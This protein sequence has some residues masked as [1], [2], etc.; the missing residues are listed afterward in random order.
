MSNFPPPTLDA[1]SAIYTCPYC[2][3]ES[4]GSGT[5][6]LHCGAPVDVRARVSA[7]GWEA[8]PA[9]KDM[10][11]IQ[12]GHSTCQI[13]GMYVPA[14]ELRLAQGE[15]V[16]FSHHTLLWADPKVQLGN[17]PMKGAWNRKMAGMDLVM[18]EATGPGTLA[19][20]D[21]HAG[22]TIAVPL[23][24]G[25]TVDV[26]E[27]RFLTASLNVSYD[28]YSPG[29]WYTTRSGDE[30]ETHYPVGMYVDRF[31]ATDTPGLLMLHGRGNVFVR[32]LQPGQ[33]ICV[34]PGSFVWKDSSVALIMHLERPASGG[35]FSSW[36]PSTPW[37]RFTGPGRVAVSSA[38]ERMENTGRIVN[39]SSCT[40]MDWNNRRASMQVDSMRTAMAGS[41]DDAPF[42]AALDAFA[43]AQGFAAGKDKNRGISKA[44]QYSHPAGI[45]VTCTVVDTSVATAA[46]GNIAGVLGSR[47]SLLSG[48]L[49]SMV[50]SL[51]ARGTSGGDQV[52]GLGFPA[53]WK[54]K[55]DTTS[56]L[57]ITKNGRTF[58]VE[59]QGQMPAQDQLG[60]L[61]AFAAAGLP[62][63]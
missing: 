1:P 8:Q 14:A 59:I 63:V 9:I 44:H 47:S 38:Y 55:D 26:R 31:S 10:A 53:N 11:K 12:F 4:D 27:H 58:T 19:L 61:K 25:K 13:S 15:G 54:R 30:T 37:L 2:R 18:M 33:T 36:Q 35:W 43:T 42:E 60:W 50:G 29:I 62:T 22:E 40:T 3:L 23:M 6:C 52:D 46:L 41:F 32:D 48:K 17:Q 34:H 24:P 16:F 21:N 28:W 51:A 20:A 57:V 5:Y 39:T 49:N 45:Q 7:S 56:V